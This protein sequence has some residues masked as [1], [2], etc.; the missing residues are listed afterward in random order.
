MNDDV[1]IYLSGKRHFLSSSV[2]ST[3]ATDAESREASWSV[4]A[5]SETRAN[6]SRDRGGGDDD[7]AVT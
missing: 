5:S 4:Y 7:D 1:I 3:G 2:A 6:A